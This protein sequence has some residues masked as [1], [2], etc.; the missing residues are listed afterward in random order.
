VKSKKTCSALTIW[1]LVILVVVVIVFIALLSPAISL[2]RKRSRHDVSNGKRVV[3]ALRYFAGVGASPA[4]AERPPSRFVTTTRS[5]SL[6]AEEL[7]P[8]P[9]DLNNKP[10]KPRTKPS[11]K[12]LRTTRRKH[13]ENENQSK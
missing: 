8:E 7:P 11:E 1:E 3:A 6:D 5:V 9:S 2:A 13:P 12:A 10:T 4:T